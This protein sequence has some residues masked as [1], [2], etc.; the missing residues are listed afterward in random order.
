MSDTIDLSKFVDRHD[1]RPYCREPMRLKDGRVVATDGRTI[2]CPDVYAGDVSALIEAPANIDQAIVQHLAGVDAATK[3]APISS[4]AFPEQQACQHCGGSGSM[5]RRECPDC[6]GEGEFDHGSHTYECKACGGDG[7][8]ESR[9]AT[10]DDPDADSCVYC[11]GEGVGGR[12]V[13]MDVPGMPKGTGVDARLMS[14]F[15]ADAEFAAGN[16]VLMRGNGWRGV[17]M[18]LRG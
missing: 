9:A 7:F 14:R 3:W 15:P 13:Y 6:D 12:A 18:P 17:V 5:V 10:R 8:V 4:L 16:S 1:F 11:G 2:A